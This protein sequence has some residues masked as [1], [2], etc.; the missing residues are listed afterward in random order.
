MVCLPRAFDMREICYKLASSFCFDRI[1]I[2]CP[3]LNILGSFDIMK[4]PLACQLDPLAEL[5]LV[6]LLGRRLRILFCY[7]GP[8]LCHDLMP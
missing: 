5:I 6:L 4:E 3:V 7:L 2:K 8:V 1:I